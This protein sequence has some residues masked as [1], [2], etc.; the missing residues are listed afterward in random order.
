MQSL[1]HA[2]SA[3]ALFG[4]V[5]LYTFSPLALGDRDPHDYPTHV[6]VEYVLECTSKAGSTLSSLYQ[7]SCVID[8]IAEQLSYDEYVESSTFSR[9]ASLA[10]EAGGIFRDPD[11]GRKL[12]K[13]YQALESA[14]FKACGVTQ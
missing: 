5:A 14:S 4:A 8:M 12:A 13:E 9:Y 6:R 1:C 2:R 10:G 11:R 7:C 3:I